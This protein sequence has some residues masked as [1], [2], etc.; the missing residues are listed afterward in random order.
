MV[1]EVG[2]EQCL[3]SG[4]LMLTRMTTR[5]NLDQSSKLHEQGW[6]TGSAGRGTWQLAYGTSLL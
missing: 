5:L 1:I 6:L 2:A 3:Y 4:C